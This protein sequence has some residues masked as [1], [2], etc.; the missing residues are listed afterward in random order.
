MPLGMML[1]RMW[2]ERRLIGVLLLAV[3]LVTGFFALEPLYVRAVSEAGIRYA[4]ANTAPSALNITLNNREPFTPETWDVISG[5]LSG[6]VTRIDSSARSAALTCGYRYSLGEPTTIYTRA[7]PNCYQFSSFSNMTDLFTVVEGRWPVRLATPAAATGAGL[8]GEQRAAQQVGVYSRGQVEAVIS[9]EAAEEANVEV[10]NRLVVGAEPSRTAIVH[11][12]GLVEPLLSLEDPFW[13]GQ[14]IMVSGQNTPIS[15]FEERFDFG[16]IVTEG[17]FNDWLAA[18]TDGN[19]YIWRLETNSDVIHADTLDLLAA[20]LERVQN[21]LQTRYPDLLVFSGL[22][23]LITVFRQ[24]VEATQGPV[25]FLTGAVLILMLYHLVTT[26]ALVLEQQGG[27]WAAISSRGGSVW[28]LIGMQLFTVSILAAVG[29]VVGPF[30]AQGILLLMERIGPLARTLQGATLGVRTLPLR[31]FVMS[32][33]AAVASAVVLTL[34]AWPAARRSLLKLKQMTSRPPMR[35]AWAR[36]GLDFVFLLVGLGFMLRLYFL[37]SG[38]VGA[39][40]E[41]LLDNPAALIR[42]LAKGVSETGGLNDPFN[43]LGP[44]LVLTG[45]ALLWLRIFPL[46][47]RLAGRLLGAVRGLTLPLAVWSVERDPGHYAQL[48]LLLIGTL[49]LGT[50][51]LALESTRDTGAWNVARHETGANVRLTLDPGQVDLGTNWLA[52]PD[53]IDGASVMVAQTPQ[54]A[55]QVQ[56]TVLGVEPQVFAAAFPAYVDAVAPLQAETPPP[57]AGLELPSEATALAL[58]VYAEVSESSFTQTQFTAR[59]IDALGVPLEVPL[60]TDDPTVSGVFVTYTA[61]LPEGLGRAPWRLTGLQI[62]SRQDGET[63]FS[64]TIYVDDV[65]VVDAGGAETVLVDFE[66][67]GLPNWVASL[68]NRQ[69]PTDLTLNRSTVQATSG[70]ASLMIAYRIREARGVVLEPS[71]TIDA[72]PVQAIPVVVSAAFAEYHGTRSVTRTSYQVGDEASV[73]LGLPFG[74]TTLFYRIV[75]IIPDFPTQS[76]RQNFLVARTD[77]LQAVLNTSAT[78]L[79]FYDWNQVWLETAQREPSQAFRDAVLVLPGVGTI[80]AAWDRYND[81]Q[82]DPLP[83]AVTGMLF[84]GFWVSLTLSVL[85]FGFYLAMTAR[86]RSVTFAVLQAMGWDGR[87]LWSLLAAEQVVLVIPALIVGVAL[88]GLLAYLLL[89]F[90]QLIGGAVLRFPVGS[91]A[92]LV[93]TLVAAFAMLLGGT[94]AF[95]RRQAIHQVLRVGDE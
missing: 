9:R 51:S 67:A 26:V 72:Q 46:L 8:T 3:C 85:D 89:P 76:D 62:N 37:I 36:Y 53:V 19:T 34:P 35:P 1:R 90:L 65:A 45:T 69:Q 58:S 87:K 6:I 44:A 33:F 38:D 82:R 14:R 64:H 63:T 41:A 66:A 23:D 30:I 28:Q 75:G 84:A 79:G 81:I 95:L 39:S 11:I 49:A 29:M 16:L 77:W 60:T 57:L 86:R 7:A 94:A 73:T 80:T 18:T 22:T 93:L 40:L 70:S 61:V 83:N 88:G 24:G 71:I 32:A 92:L 17:A 50:A 43:L 31:P 91:V 54:L 59:F 5:E 52:L 12:V 4:V 55:G 13:E 68:D 15:A 47:M 48:V 74:N 21:S 2:R 78:P 20:K 56:Q 27:E 25:M 10:G 42:S